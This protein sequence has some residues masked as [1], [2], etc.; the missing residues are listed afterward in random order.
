MSPHFP[1]PH[2]VVDMIQSFER[3][4]DS[5]QWGRALFSSDSHTSSPEVWGGNLHRPSAVESSHANPHPLMREGRVRLLVT[6]LN[7]C[8]AAAFAGF[9]C[10]RRILPPSTV[11]AARS[12]YFAPRFRLPFGGAPSPIIHR[13]VGG[14]MNAALDGSFPEMQLD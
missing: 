13:P 2:V 11:C 7:R 4:S 5:P 10:T 3:T 9:R 6:G 1:P 14:Q 12:Q 8:A